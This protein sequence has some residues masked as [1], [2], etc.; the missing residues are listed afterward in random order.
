MNYD[1]EGSLANNR[2]PT[3]KMYVLRNENKRKLKRKRGKGKKKEK[4]FKRNKTE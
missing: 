2:N 1:I 4:K 3:L